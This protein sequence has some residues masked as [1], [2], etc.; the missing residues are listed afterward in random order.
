MAT[1]T[2]YACRFFDK[3][4]NNS[5]ISTKMQ[6]K[7]FKIP[8]SA[9]LICMLLSCNKV[10][11]YTRGEFLLVQDPVT[12][13]Y[14]SN[15]TITVNKAGDYSLNVRSNVNYSTLSST[16]PKDG[17]WLNVSSSVT[18]ADGYDKVP[19]SVSAQ[20]G[21][22]LRRTGMITVSC[23]ELYLNN[24]VTIAQGHVSR[25]GSD[26]AFLKYGSANPLEGPGGRAID[27]WTESEINMGWTSTCPEGASPAC[28]GRNGFIQLG[29]ETGQGADLLT[30]YQANLVRDTVLI[31][32]FDAVAHTSAEG[33]KDTGK[34]TVSVEGGGQFI[35]GTT[36]VSATAG[37]LDPNA[38]D[39]AS[40]MW[41]NASYQYVI[42][43]APGNMITSNTRVRI[44]SGSYES[45]I[46]NRLYIKNFYLLR[47]DKNQWGAFPGVSE[48]TDKL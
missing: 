11:D 27:K 9:A 24:F 37:N 35:D 26:F 39:V 12:G 13:E 31:A 22:P 6:K 1:R 25:V 33:V 28:Y 40:D 38:S 17:E 20:T 15:P 19:F 5:F 16:L 45:T 21:V 18:G 36:T 4:A 47:V 44:M 7:F 30:P 46:P 2:R 42:I 23:P 14:V 48:I 10:K 34:F 8:L 3:F 32:Y 41:K 29:D 43:S